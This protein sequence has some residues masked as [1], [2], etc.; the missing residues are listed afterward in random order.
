MALGLA[1]AP[2]EKSK[3]KEGEREE[4]C[5]AEEALEEE[6]AQAKVDVGGE[7]ALD[8]FATAVGVLVGPPLDE[9]VGEKDRERHHRVGVEVVDFVGGFVRGKSGQMGD[10]REMR[11][12]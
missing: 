8:V 12:A 1:Q 10:K 5:G 9:E 2:E 4:E 11:K 7:D 3:A 6:A